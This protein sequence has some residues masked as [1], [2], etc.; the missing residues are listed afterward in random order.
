MEA[1][2]LQVGV[3][4]VEAHATALGDGHGLVEVAARLLEVAPRPM[5]RGPGQQTAGQFRLCP[6]P[7]QAVHSLVQVL[8]RL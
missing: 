1:G 5:Q 7:S 2:V 8:G 6:C 4:L 3:G